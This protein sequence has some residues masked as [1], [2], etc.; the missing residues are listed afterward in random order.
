LATPRAASGVGLWKPSTRGHL[1]L[2]SW[3]CGVNDEKE[4]SRKRAAGDACALSEGTHPVDVHP[5]I[6]GERSEDTMSCSC[7]TRSIQ[8]LF[9]L[10][11]SLP[12][13]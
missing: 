13:H 12:M 8:I 3:I 1:L 2:G 7:C 11:Y 6:L 10:S 5:Q 9:C 4:G